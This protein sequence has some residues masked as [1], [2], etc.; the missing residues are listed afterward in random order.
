[1][2]TGVVMD[3]G[4]K[5]RIRSEFKCPRDARVKDEIIARCTT[6]NTHQNI[7]IYFFN[8]GNAYKSE[9]Q[10]H[11]CRSKQIATH[12]AF[13]ICKYLQEYRLSR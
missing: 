4:N 5:L 2:A 1:M 12:L 13:A 7:A 3:R 10:R 9:W 8:R 11:S 6:C